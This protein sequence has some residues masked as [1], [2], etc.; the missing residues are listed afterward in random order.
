[1]VFVSCDPFISLLHYT[2]SVETSYDLIEYISEEVAKLRAMRRIWA[3]MLKEKFK[4]KNRRSLTWRT[5]IQ[6]S[7]LPFTVQQPLNNIVR[8]TIQRLAAVLAGTQSIHTTSYD[9]A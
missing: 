4:A 2:N 9:E 1:M 5:A 6:T 7:A 3:R 8:A